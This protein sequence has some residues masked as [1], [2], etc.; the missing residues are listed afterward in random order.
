MPSEARPRQNP[1]I[2]PEH[3][4]AI[5]RRIVTAYDRPDFDNRRLPELAAAVTDARRLLAGAVVEGKD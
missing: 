4:A 2:N 3:A 1:L 5:L